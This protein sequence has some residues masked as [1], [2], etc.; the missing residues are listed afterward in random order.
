M[1]RLKKYSKSPYWQVRGTVAG[2]LIHKSTG[3]ANRKKAEKFRFN[4][5][6]QTYDIIALGEAPPATFA[7]AAIVYVNKGGETKYLKRISRFF[8]DTPLREIGQ[9]EIDRAAH[10]LYPNAKASTIN[11]SLISPY[12]TVVRAAIKA[13]LPGAV[14]RPIER[15]KESKPVVTPADDEHIASLLPYCSE[16]LAALITLMTYTG[17]R[18]GEALRVKQE[19]CKDGFIQIGTTKNG[20]PR[21]VPEPSGWTYPRS[22]F[23]FS[24]TQGV[25]RA[26]RAAHKRA[27]LSYRDGHELGRHAFASRWLAAGNSIKGLKEAGGW[28]KL[29]VVDEKYGHLEQTA[30]HEVMRELSRKK[31]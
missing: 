6:N 25:G 16:G 3:T 11:R 15:R 9:Q 7:D 13:E 20:E 19:D 12:I 30:V 27:A 31:T 21:M 23:G 29:A 5:E 18:T 28:K 4:L 24:S 17:L 1:L 22:G 10:E 14:L 8:G 2:R 26:L